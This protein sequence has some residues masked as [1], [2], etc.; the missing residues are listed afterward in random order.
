[1]MRKN[2]GSRGLQPDKYGMLILRRVPRIPLF[3]FVLNN[4]TK[5]A[6]TS[7]VETVLRMLC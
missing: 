3:T 7:Y 2:F 5:L 4:K 1:M 6:S